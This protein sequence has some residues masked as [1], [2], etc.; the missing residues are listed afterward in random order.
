MKGN[1]S[2]LKFR[3]ISILCY[4]KSL[5]NFRFSQQYSWG[6]K[7]S[8]ML[9]HVHCYK[10]TDVSE[11]LTVSIFRDIK[12]SLILPTA[13][14]KPCDIQIT[15]SHLPCILYRLLS[16]D[17]LDCTTLKMEAARSSETISS[18]YQSTRR[19]IPKDCMVLIFFRMDLREISGE[20]RSRWNGRVEGSGTG[21]RMLQLEVLLPQVGYVF[22][23]PSSLLHDGCQTPEST[24]LHL[25][26][27]DL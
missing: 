14:Q 13:M 21:L 23:A 8:A 18:I 6:F 19:H 12:Q 16:A 9:H 7:F 4:A 3:N 26:A 15:H 2:L 24:W 10:G 22:V 5:R 27:S 11:Q 1:G 25:Y 20:K 17:Y